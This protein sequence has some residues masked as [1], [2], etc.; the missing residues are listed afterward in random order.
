MKWSWKI[1]ELRGIGVFVHATFLIL[2]GFVVL[3]H[4]AVGH[5]LA[6]T[7]EGVAFVLALFVCVVLHEFGHALTA[8]RFGI[9]TRDITLFPIGGVA[10]L[11]RMPEVPLHELWVALAGPAVNVA[12]ALAL[13][14]G[15]RLGAT[16][17]PL[18]RLSVAGGPVLERLML[19]NVALAAFN[20]VPAFPMDGGRVLRAA[21][22][23]RLDYTRATWIAASAGQ[24]IALVFGLVGFFTNPF[25]MFI[26]LFVW[27]GAAQEAGLVEMRSALTG[28]PVARAMETVF[29]TLA[30]DDP[31]ARAI[32]ATLASAQQDFP[33][34][35]AGTVVGVLTRQDLLEGLARRGA[36]AAVRGSMQRDFATIEAG[37]M[38]DAAFRRLEGKSS[39]T[40][41]VTQAGALVGLVTLDNVGDFLAIRSALERKRV[42]PRT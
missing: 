31:L 19:V 7:L 37:E 34:I 8:A 30:P 36:D 25:L 5:D 21:L 32:D 24:A 2:I 42:P 39:R 3:S 16:I 12:I 18:D 9:R 41:P 35:E 40:L 22:A 4:W 11:E 15:L 20:L 1:A 10:R 17:G 14:V 6:K 29:T 28:I 13:F 33:V 26:A 23:T 27:I 38:L